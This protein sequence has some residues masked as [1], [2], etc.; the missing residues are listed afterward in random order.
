MATCFIPERPREN[1]FSL[2][3]EVDHNKLLNIFAT[4]SQGLI[5]MN[6]NLMELPREDYVRYQELINK[7]DFHIEND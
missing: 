7:A 6:C 2:Y 4:T 1:T 5:K 3:V